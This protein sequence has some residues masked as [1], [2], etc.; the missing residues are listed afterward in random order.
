MH[1]PKCDAEHLHTADCCTDEPICGLDEIVEE[2]ASA[3]DADHV[4]TEECYAPDCQHEHDGDVAAVNAMIADNK[5][6]A[7]KDDPASWTFAKWDDSAP[8]RITELFFC[9]VEVEK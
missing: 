5:L 1:T 8:K 3:S 7:I 2:T 9:M 6:S 4:H